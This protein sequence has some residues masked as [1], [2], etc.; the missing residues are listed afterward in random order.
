MGT[1][2]EG[3]EQDREVLSTRLY[4]EAVS[5]SS[6]WSLTTLLPAPER[7]KYFASLKVVSTTCVLMTQ[8]VLRVYEFVKCTDK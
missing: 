1:Q 7:M 8:R 3:W 2:A 4:W 5:L 6:M